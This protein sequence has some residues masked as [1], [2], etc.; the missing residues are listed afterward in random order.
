MNRLLLSDGGWFDAEAAEKWD[1]E[2]DYDS[3]ENHPLCRQ[4]LWR[5]RNSNFVLEN[6]RFHRWE[7]EERMNDR[8]RYTEDQAIRWF[9]MYNQ[10]IPTDLI[11][12]IADLEL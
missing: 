8:H 9:L 3:D 1:V 6:W 12:K 7:G 10:E 5:T 2:F 11:Q 4:V